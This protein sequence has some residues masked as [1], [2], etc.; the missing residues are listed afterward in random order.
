MKARLVL[1]EGP[2][3]SSGQP[4][5]DLQADILTGRPPRP[6]T[7]P[8]YLLD[9]FKQSVLSMG[10]GT[11]CDIVV[12]D[13]QASRYHS[14][15]RWNGRQW[16]VVDRGSTN[17]T[18]V[19]GMQIHGPYELHLGDRITIG[20]TTMVLHEFGAAPDHQ[21]S[22][23]LAGAARKAYAVPRPMETPR[24][25]TS[26]AGTTVAFWLAQVLVAVAVVCLAAGAFLPWFRVTGSLSRD[27][28]PILQGITDIVSSFLGEDLLSI[29]QDI[30]GLGGFGKV[31][32]GLAVICAIL[33]IVDMAGTSSGFLTRR[34]V[35]AAV[36]YLVTSLLAIAVIAAELKNVYDL[37]D[38]VQSMT[39]LLGIRLA[40]VVE[41]F[42]KF[43][44]LKVTFLPGLYLT[45]AGLAF[46]LVGGVV[47]LVVAIL[48]WR[49]DR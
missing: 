30:S 42:G 12:Q 7:T 29:T 3:A 31:S 48:G 16:E 45:V 25:D 46:L 5:V 24:Q 2:S 8:T 32:L 6:Q 49:A 4:R 27:M 35:V 18:Y 21:T 39:L 20:D 14:D 23:D 11:Q 43:I 13:N 38:Q 10:R 9:P 28:A 40:D 33:L 37:Y 34:S 22:R 41:A 47:R 15:I 1:Q 44:E 17:G 26:T 19:N 36:V